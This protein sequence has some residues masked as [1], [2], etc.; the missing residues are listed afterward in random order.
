MTPTSVRKRNPLAA[1]II[2]ATVSTFSINA[3]AQL[4]EVIVNRAEAC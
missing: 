2:A 3:A 1:A 4:E